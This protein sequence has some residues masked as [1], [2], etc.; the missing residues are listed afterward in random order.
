MPLRRRFV[1]PEKKRM[2]EIER[3][4]SRPDSIGQRL[5]VPVHHGSIENAE[6]KRFPWLR[7][8]RSR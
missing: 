4:Y 3:Q 8:R 5:R 2:S 7:K 6:E 1:Q